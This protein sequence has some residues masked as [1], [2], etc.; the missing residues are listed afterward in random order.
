[1]LFCFIYWCNCQ[2][3]KASDQKTDGA[4]GFSVCVRECVCVC[5]F[6]NLD[7]CF[8]LFWYSLP[9]C[10]SPMHRYHYSIQ[11]NKQYTTIKQPI[12]SMVLIPLVNL[13]NILFKFV[14]FNRT[15]LG[16]SF[17]TACI[18]F[19]CII[20]TRTCMFSVVFEGF[21]VVYKCFHLLLLNNKIDIM[22][23][24]LVPCCKMQT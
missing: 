22:Y 18:I 3:T 7:N 17:L 21:C 5:V 13:F 15:W 19:L 10:K 16:S 6:V 20:I 4:M 12:F 23:L 9:A 11:K 24:S 2:G 1:M 14:I 8:Q